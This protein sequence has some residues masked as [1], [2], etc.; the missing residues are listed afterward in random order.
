MYSE[1][2]RPAPFPVRPYL[3]DERNRLYLTNESDSVI[4]TYPSPH[5]SLYIALYIGYLLLA[6]Y[7]WLT[8]NPAELL[9]G[10]LVIMGAML[11]ALFGALSSEVGAVKV[12]P[13]DAILHGTVTEVQGQ[14]RRQ[15]IVYKIAYHFTTADGQPRT[16]RY[17]LVDNEAKIRGIPDVGQPVAIFYRSAKQYTIL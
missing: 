10:G 12:T 9:K 14:R 2:P 15:I 13:T 17:E 3:H 7:I 8:Q 1:Q 11:L 5:L 4:I 16:G 6:T